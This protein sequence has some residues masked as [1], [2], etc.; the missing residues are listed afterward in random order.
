[1]CAR[2]P[3]SSL[4]RSLVRLYVSIYRFSTDVDVLEITSF[5]P[6]VSVTPDHHYKLAVGKTI[7]I[8]STT[9]LTTSTN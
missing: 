1:M 8:I 7:S 3:L 6:H 4:P 5:P 2:L 9:P